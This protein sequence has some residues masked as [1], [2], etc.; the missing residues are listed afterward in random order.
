MHHPAWLYCSVPKPWKQLH[1]LRPEDEAAQAASEQGTTPGRG[2]HTAFACTTPDLR[3]QDKIHFKYAIESCN[4]Q[5]IQ[6]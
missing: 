1:L 5:P 2:A 6:A 3:G 4:F